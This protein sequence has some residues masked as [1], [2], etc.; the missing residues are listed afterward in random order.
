MRKKAKRITLSRETL[1]VLSTSHLEPAVGGTGETDGTCARSACQGS[2]QWTC[3]L[4]LNIPCD[5]DTC[6]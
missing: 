3:Y 1:R 6:C 5:T 2:C 4:S